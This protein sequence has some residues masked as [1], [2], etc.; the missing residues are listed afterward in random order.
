MGKVVEAGVR[1][2]HCDTLCSIACRFSVRLT[3]LNEFTRFCQ[4]INTGLEE[5]L[6]R[7]ARVNSSTGMSSTEVH[8]ST[9]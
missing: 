8:E 6:Q 5:L 1:L 4:R 2:K 9:V 3:K 7:M